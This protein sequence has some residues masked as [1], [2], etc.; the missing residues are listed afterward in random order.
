[1]G[2]CQ[3]LREETKYLGFIIDGNRIKPDKVE[4]IS[5]KPELKTV[6]Q[7]RGFIEAIGHYR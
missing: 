3:L 1:M 2:K 5:E 4:A 7:V 6:R